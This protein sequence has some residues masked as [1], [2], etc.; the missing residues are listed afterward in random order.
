MKNEEVY[1]KITS[2]QKKVREKDD[3]ED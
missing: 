1:T 2:E 3:S